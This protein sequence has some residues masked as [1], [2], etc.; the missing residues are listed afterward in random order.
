VNKDAAVAGYVFGVP[1]LTWVHGQERQ[2][3]HQAMEECGPGEDNRLVVLS[4]QLCDAYSDGTL[5][6]A[7]EAIKAANLGPNQ[8]QLLAIGYRRVAASIALIKEFAP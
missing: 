1:S 5:A 8:R 2:V 7:A 4:R 3:L 6:A